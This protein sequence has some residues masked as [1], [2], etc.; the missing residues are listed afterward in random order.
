MK[1]EFKLSPNL[2][3]VPVNFLR[4]LEVYAPKHTAFNYLNI[5]GDQF[6]DIT[7]VVESIFSS[8]T[9]LVSFSILF[10]LKS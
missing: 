4:R 3:G 9:I 5:I 1:E 10:Q 6:L 2:G 7:E 8:K